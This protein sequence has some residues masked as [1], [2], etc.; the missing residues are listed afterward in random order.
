MALNA[1]IN[2]FKDKGPIKEKCF[3]CQKK[4][5]DNYFTLPATE[6]YNTHDQT[7]AHIK[8]NRMCSV[9]CMNHI[10]LSKNAKEYNGKTFDEYSDSDV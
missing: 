8:Q 6:D 4:L 9:K 3:V 5:K 10:A 1:Y 7:R 2:D